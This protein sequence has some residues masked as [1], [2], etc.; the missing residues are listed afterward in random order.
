MN[1]ET[2]ASADVADRQAINL[3]ADN[4]DPGQSE[5]LPRTSP[6]K[7]L[8]ISQGEYAEIIV[9]RNLP[10]EISKKFRG[11]VLPNSMNFAGKDFGDSLNLSGKKI[12]A[13][14]TSRGKN[15]YHACVP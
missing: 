15:S 7:F 5:R 12:S 14:L 11:L 4:P 3:S 8:R 1:A 6:E 10:P 13:Y 2:V 9:P